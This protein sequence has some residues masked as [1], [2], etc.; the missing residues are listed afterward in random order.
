MRR[1]VAIAAVA[2]LG[3]AATAHADGKKKCEPVGKGKAAK[4][5]G[6]IWIESLAG[7]FMMF[8]V[9]G[10]GTSGVDELYLVTKRDFKAGNVVA[11]LV[12]TQRSLSD[13]P[14]LGPDRGRTLKYWSSEDGTVVE[15]SGPGKLKR[16]YDCGGGM[17]SE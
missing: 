13:A 12:G 11:T 17:D 1:L 15:F 6:P 5:G 3:A 2:L 14:K 7:D 10:R 8:R 16:N 9:G 4:S